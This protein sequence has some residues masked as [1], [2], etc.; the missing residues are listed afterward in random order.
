MASRKPAATAKPRPS[1]SVLF[2]LD[3][4]DRYLVDRLLPEAPSP[5][6]WAAVNAVRHANRAWK[7]REI[8]P[9]MAMFRAITGEEES[10][11][12][13]F[14]A[15]KRLR[16]IDAELLNPWNHLQKNA[17][18]PFIEAVHAAIAPGMGE[19]FK[20]FALGVN[21]SEERPVVRLTLT[22]K[23]EGNETTAE[24][25]PPLHFR[26]NHW[27]TGQPERVWDFEDK[28]DEM[29]MRTG[30]DSVQDALRTRANLR[31]RLL[32]AA[33]DGIPTVMPPVEPGL[34]HARRNTFRNLKLYLMI[35]GHPPGQLFV[36]QALSAFVKMLGRVP[37]GIDFD[38]PPDFTGHLRRPDIERND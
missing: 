13:I 12:A 9:Q 25:T 4:F 2:P 32:Y 24:P 18:T 36:Q 8:D 28:I 21:D 26:V 22:L 7:L 33:P 20:G 38:G 34:E 17:V 16:Y 23:K 5:G 30:A 1:D 19:F 15:L 3:D 11:T 35:D 27:L 14:H 6:K 10:A 29:A 31:N 37:K